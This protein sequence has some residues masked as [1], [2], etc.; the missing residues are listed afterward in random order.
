MIG[1]GEQLTG[2]A[3]ICRAVIDDLQGVGRLQ[4]VAVNLNAAGSNSNAAEIGAS[5]NK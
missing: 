4:F 5:K 3:A 1:S 2:A